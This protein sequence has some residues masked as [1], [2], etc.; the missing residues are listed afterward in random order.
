MKPQKLPLM[1]APVARTVVRAGSASPWAGVASAAILGTMAVVVA[2]L[3]AGCTRDTAPSTSG[4][5]V[6]RSPA[7]AA[8]NEIFDTG[9]SVLFGQ[10]AQADA[11]SLESVLDYLNQWAQAQ[12]ADPDWRPDPL[13]QSLPERARQLQS[14]RSLSVMRFQPSDGAEL[15]QAVWLR[16]ISQR[17][18]GGERAPLARAERLFDWTVRNI[19]I[20]KDDWTTIPL[21]PRETLLLGRGA[22]IDRAWIFVLL[23][24]QQELPAVVL[25][26]ADESTPG[27]LRPW[28][29]AVLIGDELYLFD[30]R[31]GLPVPGPAG[32]GVATLSQAADDPSVLK[33]LDVE[34][35]AYPVA[36]DQAQEVVALIEASPIYL[37]QRMRKAES[38]LAGDKRLY[39]SVAPQEL[40]ARLE[41]LPHV[42]SARLWTLPYDRVL[43]QVEATPETVAAFEAELAPFSPLH[44]LFSA[45]NGE[46]LWKRIAA[47]TKDQF[48]ATFGESINARNSAARLARVQDFLGEKI[49][50]SGAA[51]AYQRLRLPDAAIRA[52][53]VPPPSATPEQA[54]MLAERMAPIQDVLRRRKQMASYWLGLA[55]YAEENYPAAED[56][57]RVRTLEAFPNGPW[58]SGARYNLA[59]TYEAQ[60]KTAEA[61]AMYL[62]DRSPQRAGSLLRAERLAPR[63][64]DLGPAAKNAPLPS[65]EPPADAASGP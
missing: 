21:T 14:L 37:A 42:A 45:A 59:R 15:E 17:A 40:A 25:A 20:E 18:V 38:R 27:G 50:G 4:G 24:R 54:A 63:P 49:D 1:I 30:A 10:G 16:R 13:L 41:H 7:Q 22:W 11:R 58:T 43:A 62:Q 28:L 51:A 48:E 53:T 44:E 36:A 55:N 19:Q 57:L 33:Q 61:A 12:P 5:D 8:P 9:M 64:A 65:S 52:N 56:Y 60:G 39:L 26:I 6:T 3:S 2:A 29:P 46:A 47:D 23:C 31:I 32:R 35:I 34:D